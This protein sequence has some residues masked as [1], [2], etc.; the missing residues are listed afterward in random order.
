MC[1][2]S[3]PGQSAYGTTEN[4]RRDLDRRLASGVA[5]T[6]VAKAAIQTVSWLSFFL[7][8]RLLSP[9]DFGLLGMTAIFL[10]LASTLSECGIDAAIIIAPELPSVK[11]RQLHT[12]SVMLGAGGTVLAC[13]AARPLATFFHTQQLTQILP[14][15][16]LM[17]TMT[18]F[19]VVPQALLLRE[20]RFRTISYIEI[21][22]G[23]LQSLTAVLLAWWKWGYWALVL[24]GLLGAAFASLM[25][26]LL[27]RC[28]FARPTMRQIRNELSFSGRLLVSRLSWYLYSNADFVVAGRFLGKEALGIYTASWNIANLP[29]EKLTNLV[30]RVTPSI[31]SRIQS[32]PEEIRR[33]L[34]LVTEV[35]SIA[36]FPVGFGL[37]LVSQS[38]VVAVFDPRWRAAATPLC[39]LALYVVPRCITTVLPQCL[40][41]TG[42][43]RFVMWQSLACLI[44]LPPSF[45]LASQ[46]GGTGIA[47]TWLC[48]FPVL[49]L[50]LFGRV[51]RR[52]KMP[53]SEYLAA[54]RPALA[55][56]SAMIAAVLLQQ[57]FTHALSP[58]IRLALSVLTGAAVYSTILLVFY[59]ERLALFLRVIYR[60]KSV[61]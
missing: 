52:L 56:S 33:Y 15:M 27:R 32:E 23:L 38:L 45:V 54:I 41:I 50:P 35:L 40:A 10:G 36:T 20:M 34:R 47:A 28:G 4:G 12:V 9:S 5:W 51:F 6:A 18:G 7:L 39:L 1:R 29:L 37:A 2:M 60:K 24:S 30:T 43:I 55:A 19:R 31:F 21:G 17:L 25:P 44:V 16:G 57:Y 42:D 13:L 46:W 22:Q 8:T 49:T 48:V 11:I 3:I 59:R 58:I 26:F 61:A 53:L 14:V